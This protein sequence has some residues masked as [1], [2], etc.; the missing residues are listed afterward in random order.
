MVP[1]TKETSI[2]MK[3]KEMQKKHKAMEAYTTVGLL[4]DRKMEKGLIMVLTAQNT[5][6]IGNSIRFQG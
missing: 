3:N 2:V 6:V 1:S 4:K 5:P